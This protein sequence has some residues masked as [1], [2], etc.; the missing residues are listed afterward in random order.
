MNQM[1]L[2]A[3]ARSSESDI[4]EPVVFPTE[5]VIVLFPLTVVPPLTLIMLPWMQLNVYWKTICPSIVMTGWNR[6]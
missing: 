6:A 1:I 5:I 4:S 2:I 3:V